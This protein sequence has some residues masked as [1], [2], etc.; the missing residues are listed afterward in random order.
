MF[1]F[2]GVEIPMRTVCSLATYWLTILIAAF[3]ANAFIIRD[4]FWLYARVW[5]AAWLSGLDEWTKFPMTS[6]RHPVTIL[7]ATIPTE[8]DARVLKR[9]IREIIDHKIARPKG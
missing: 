8:A 4:F 1:G 3:G 7:V 2:R 5:R 6:E 9:K